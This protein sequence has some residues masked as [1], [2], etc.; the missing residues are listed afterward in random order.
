M[1]AGGVDQ[2]GAYDVLCDSCKYGEFLGHIRAGFRGSR[3]LWPAPPPVRAPTKIIFFICS[4]FLNNRLKPSI[5]R[6]RI[7]NDDPSS[8][9]VP[10]P[11]Q[12]NPVLSV[13]S[14]QNGV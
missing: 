2:G 5:N 8:M 12:L 9:L 1:A 10:G 11:H 6:K 14:N 13:E 4:F 7:I 3:G